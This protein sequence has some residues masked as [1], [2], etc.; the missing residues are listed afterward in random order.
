MVSFN[1][2]HFDISY[3]LDN[4]LVCGGDKPIFDTFNGARYEDFDTKIFNILRFLIKGF[5][6]IKIM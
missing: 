1:L 3:F 4:G 6:I 2:G 5:A